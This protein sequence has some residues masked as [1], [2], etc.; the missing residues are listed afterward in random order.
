MSAARLLLLVILSS[1]AW[2]SVGKAAGEERPYVHQL[3]NDHMVFPRDI[4]APVWGWCEPG[5]EVT[6]AM[7]DKSAKAIA[8]ADGR[9][10]VKIGPFG[11][12]GPH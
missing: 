3:F 6:V 1:T 11:A 2:L 12:G 4:E 8:G 10:Q 7:G 9:W 5:K